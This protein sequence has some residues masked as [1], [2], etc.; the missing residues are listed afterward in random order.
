IA[1]SRSSSSYTAISSA[2]SETA[3]VD[4]VVAVGAPGPVIPLQPVSTATDAA[5]DIVSTQRGVRFVARGVKEKKYT[6]SNTSRG[7][8]PDYFCPSSKGFRYCPAYEPPPALPSP[9]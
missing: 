4:E 8:Y 5:T 2:I 9:V 6:S 7:N 3:A 1:A